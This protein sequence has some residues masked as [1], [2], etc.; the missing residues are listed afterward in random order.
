M[1]DYAA[2]GVVSVVI[3]A[4]SIISFGIIGLRWFNGIVPR[5]LM[6]VNATRLIVSDRSPCGL[7]PTVISRIDMRAGAAIDA[8]QYWNR[9]YDQ[10]RQHGQDTPPEGCR[11]RSAVGK[12]GQ[13]FADESLRGVG[14]PVHEHRQ[15]ET[16]G[17]QIYGA[18]QEASPVMF[19]KRKNISCAGDSMMPL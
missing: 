19:A 8:Q 18:D 1:P 11:T 3:T 5:L 9:R 17:A 14:A 6:S 13:Q 16:S 4:F 2:S 12:T 10:Q 7:P 15:Q